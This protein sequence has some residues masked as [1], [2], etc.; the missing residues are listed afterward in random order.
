MISCSF[1]LFNKKF[2]IQPI[3]L[4][5]KPEPAPMNLNFDKVN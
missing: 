2:N 5:F 3:I 4:K 1:N